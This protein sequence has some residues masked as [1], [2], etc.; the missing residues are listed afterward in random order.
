MA[1]FDYERDIQTIVAEIV[2]VICA[3]ETILR[4]CAGG[5]LPPYSLTLDHPTSGSAVTANIPPA[6]VMSNF[7]NQVYL[8]RLN[9][10]QTAP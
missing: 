8:A 7:F 4:L 3:H 5:R 9:R 2:H 10:E 1:A 6:S